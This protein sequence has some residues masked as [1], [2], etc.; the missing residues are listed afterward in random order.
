M[1]QYV[2]GVDVGGTKTAYGVFDGAGQIVARRR[3]RSDD[4]LSPEAFF[5]G[6]A[7][8]VRELMEEAG[9][10]PG[11]L[12]G[13]GIGMPSFIL[14]EEGR[15][16]KTTNLTK[17][18]DF[19]ARAYLMEK[20]GGARVLLDNDSHT[21]ALAEFRP[22]RGA[23]LPEHR[24]LPGEHRHLVGHRHRR[25]ALPGPV[26]LV[27]GERAH[28]RHARRGDRVRLRATAAAS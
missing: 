1:E 4:S 5:D 22:R 18:R 6:V 28:D 13:V 12:R 23:R 24:L 19:P 2:I 20:L 10:A 21:G 7:A 17:I 8:N 25:Q 11:N 3:C 26:R 15:I 27:G 16:V 14:F 9:I